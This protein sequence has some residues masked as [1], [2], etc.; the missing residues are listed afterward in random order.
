M[1]K[2]LA[3]GH[4]EKEF[5][6]DRCIIT[7]AVHT[8]A[9]TAAK[10][11]EESSTQC[12]KLLQHLDVI[13]I[14]PNMATICEDSIEINR[15]SGKDR[16][17]YLSVREIRIETGIDQRLIGLIR[18]IVESGLNNITL[19]VRYDIADKVRIRQLLLEQAIRD[20]R[21]KAELLA[22]SMGQKIVGIDSANLSGRDDIED[23]IEDDV[24]GD[25]LKDNRYVAGA[26]C[27]ER[28][29]SA[30]PLTDQLEPKNISLSTD[31]KIIWQME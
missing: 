15:Y 5:R 9:V 16:E 7:L 27:C 11:S 1:G 24:L 8:N 28:A 3:I 18:H 17:P 19:G 29:R 22:S 23:V 26:M 10:A 4:V 13:G 21:H 12:E 14:K 6:P 25:V 31:V 20:S 30:T 2:V